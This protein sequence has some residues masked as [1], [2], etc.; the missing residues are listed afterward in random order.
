MRTLTKEKIQ[1]LILIFQIIF[2]GLVF[3]ATAQ[4]K[5]PSIALI[6]I[7]TKGLEAD[8][9]VMASIVRLEL[10]KTNHFEV[11]DKYDV[12]DVVTQNNINPDTYFG[13]N[14]VV[15]VGKILDTDKMLTGSVERFG[16]K[17][18]MIFRLIDV[19]EER[20][21]KTA[22]ME[23]LNIQ[24]EIQNMTMLCLNELLGIEN[25]PYM[26]DL[27]VEYDLPI[28]S[29]K[30]SV[31]LN[32]PRI[33]MVYTMGDTGQRLQ[34]PKNEGGY[35]MFPVTT[36]FGYQLE[37]QYLSAGD[38]QAL[39]EGVFAVNGLESGKFIPSITFLNGFRFNTSGIEFA[40]GPVFRLVKTTDGFYQDGKWIR[41]VDAYEIPEGTEIVERLD[42][43]GVY[44]L[45]LGMVVAVGKTFRSGYLNI[46]VNAY[47][48]PRKNGTTIGLTF[49]F[50]TTAKPKL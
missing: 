3:A 4:P 12:Q 46:P 24:S 15:K 32:G 41:T 6:S 48:I 13:K 37:K 29:T 22:V 23:F 49:G 14:N 39:I 7:D 11:L 5:K 33:G 21:E 8:N 44:N 38:F 50:N 10:E 18:I 30:T 16:D 20:I 25:D 17:I 45:S 9:A 35:D 19:Q 42:N 34:D 1:W 40:T 26:V 31:N 36:M 43:R 27:L 2:L 47:M 28:A